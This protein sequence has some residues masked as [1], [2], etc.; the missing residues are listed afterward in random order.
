MS[1]DVYS[2]VFIDNLPESLTWDYQV[3]SIGMVSDQQAV[4]LQGLLPSLLV[5]C[6]IPNQPENVLDILAFQFGVL[7]YSPANSITDPVQRLAV[8]Q[9]LIANNFNYHAHLGTPAV[10]QE[11]ASSIYGPVQIQEWPQYGGTA[12]HFRALIPNP[13]GITPAQIQQMAQLINVVKRASQTFEG[14]FSIVQPPPGPGGQVNVYVAVGVYTQTI[15][16]LP[17]LT[18]P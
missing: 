5:L 14:F 7:F 15:L 2:D 1:N 13:G 10:V 17:I 16:V 12:N 9:Q 6:N 4:P 18:A 11:I 8:K 3:Q